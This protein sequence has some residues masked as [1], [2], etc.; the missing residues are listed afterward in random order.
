MHKE[1][2][3]KVVELPKEAKIEM[4]TAP[5]SAKMNRNK[6]DMAWYQH[7]LLFLNVLLHATHLNKTP[8]VDFLSLTSLL[9]DTLLLSDRIGTLYN[10]IL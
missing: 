1:K 6:T 7:A 4:I 10:R 5:S 9:A 3:V 2:G 8:V